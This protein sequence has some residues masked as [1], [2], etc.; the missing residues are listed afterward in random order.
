MP[1][2]LLDARSITRRHAVRTVLD[3]VDLRVDAGSRI[4]L[5]GANGAGKSTLLRILAGLE[6]SDGG[7]VERRGSVGYLPQLTDRDAGSL[8]ETRALTGLD[9]ASARTA[10]ARGAGRS[11]P[12]TRDLPPARRALQ[13]SRHRVARGGA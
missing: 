12:P 2:T 10:L 11:R 13:P 1:S 8:T 3:A 7:T 5:I 4:A 9:D 6:P